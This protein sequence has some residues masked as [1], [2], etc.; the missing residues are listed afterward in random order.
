MLRHLSVASQ[1]TSAQLALQ[2][3]YSL[4]REK[5]NHMKK[6]PR[7]ARQHP[8]RRSDPNQTAGQQYSGWSAPGAYQ[9]QPYDW[10][11]A[12]QPAQ[13]PYDPYRGAHQSYSASA[14]TAPIPQPRKRPR[15][16][17]VIVGAAAVAV[18]TGGVGAVAVAAQPHLQRPLPASPFRPLVNPRRVCRPVRLSRLPRRWCPAW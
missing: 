16:G 17:V 18:V 11:Y 14:P 7:Y 6:H 15:A 5:R 9:Q 13:P 1:S 8:E 12:Q 3:C 10:R 2:L 4:S